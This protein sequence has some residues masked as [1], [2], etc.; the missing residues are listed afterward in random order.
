MGVP[1]FSMGA[2]S[3]AMG[4]PPFS[5]GAGSFKMGD[6]TGR[7]SFFNASLSA[8]GV[9]QVGVVEGERPPTPGSRLRAV[10]VPVQRV[11]PDA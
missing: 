1:P 8:A 3:F 6:G 10:Q 4:A 9:L 2:G 5:M 11:T 7:D